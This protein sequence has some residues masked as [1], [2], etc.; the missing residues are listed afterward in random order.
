MERKSITITL[1]YE[2][3]DNELAACP[4]CNTL[5]FDKNV[6]P[7]S[8][9][10]CSIC[11]WQDDSCQYSDHDLEESSNV[12]SLNQA[13]EN[14][15]HRATSDLTRL[16]RIRKLILLV[17]IYGLKLE[18]KK[19]STDRIAKNKSLWYYLERIISALFY[20]RFSYDNMDKVKTR[21]SK[22]YE[23]E[24]AIDLNKFAIDF[25]KFMERI[26]IER[27]DEVYIND[28][29]WPDL[30]KQ[31]SDLVELMQKNNHKYHFEYSYIPYKDI[32]SK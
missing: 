7:G 8:E 23:E 24:E 21:I 22:F 10:I 4:V 29:E 5:E 27:E 12:V 13:K 26:G 18:E 1:F 6:F 14:Y 32:S 30:Q 28:H 2:V 15:K 19:S 16:E 31:A 3:N 9:E 11:G 20:P 17:L 25:K